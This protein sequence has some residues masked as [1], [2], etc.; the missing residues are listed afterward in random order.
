MGIKG[1]KHISMPIF[2]KGKILVLNK[3]GVSLLGLLQQQFMPV[4]CA[5][6]A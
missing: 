4:N 6:K 5:E 2:R 3:Y 1:V